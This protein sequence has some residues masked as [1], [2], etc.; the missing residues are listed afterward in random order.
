LK[1]P[2][3]KFSESEIN[4]LVYEHLG[5]T[6]P[7]RYGV[8]V[9]Y[10]WRNRVV[11]LLDAEEFIRV[12]TVRNLYKIT[13]EE[14]KK[15]GTKKVGIIGL[16]VG[17]SVA[18]AIATQRIAGEI[19]LADFDTLELSNMNRIRTSVLNLGLPK[20]EIVAR[21]IAELDPFLKV[22]C[23]YDGINE[24]NI[25][26]FFTKDG[27]IDVLIEECDSVE[28][29][30][31]SRQIAKKLRV[32]VVMDTSD[33]GMIDI[34]RFDLTPEYPLLH[35]LIDE[36][37]SYQYLKSLKGSK[38]K[39]PYILPFAGIDNISER[40]AASALEIESSITSWPQLGS[41]VQIG[42]GIAASYALNILLGK[43]VESGRHY[44]DIFDQTS[45]N[46]TSREKKIEPELKILNP[47]FNWEIVEK[48]EREVFEREIVIDIL[49]KAIESPSPGN[50]QKWKFVLREK[51]ICIFLDKEY[52][53]SVGDNLGYSSILGIGALIENISLLMIAYRLKPN[54]KVFEESNFPLICV[55]ALENWHEEL[56]S[57]DALIA[58]IPKRRT[59]RKTG[60]NRQLSTLEKTA[61]EDIL[62][63]NN[64]CLVKT[65]EEL[66][67]ITDI[68]NIIRSGD[69]IRLQ[70]EQAHHE[71]F[72]NELRWT[73]EE[74]LKWRTGIEVEHLLLAP[75][76]N[77]ALKIAKR[78]KPIQ[79]LKNLGLGKG[80]ERIS[81][82]AI[83]NSSAIVCIF[84]QSYNYND[85]VAAGRTIQRYWLKA[86]ELHIGIQPMTFVL[87]LFSLLE[88]DKNNF[89]NESE[90]GEL[91][92][93][94]AQ[95]DVLFTPVEKTVPVFLFRVHKVAFDPEKTLRVPVS[96]KILEV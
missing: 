62:K 95:F 10:P 29:K 91:K 23:Y 42:G 73:K 11:H 81:I 45:S 4:K 96:A 63:P 61:L 48:E 16:S 57:E 44:L 31:H 55:I 18:M 26:E 46:Y 92:E 8:W 56:L 24:D 89:L 37:L 49:N 25:H 69:R 14:Q 72:I 15:L 36:N 2:F 1:Y 20:V 67:L 83:E 43:K 6:E 76:D 77:A 59:N 80:F 70:N 66:G 88:S 21:E 7:E 84:V 71:F 40:M 13:P 75:A 65:I 50:N 35:G 9:F 17:H 32:P 34:E 27:N 86:T 79:F 85:L 47:N 51:S 52:N 30:I 90:L 78:Y 3:K 33:R 82:D 74:S 60:S 38:E 87:S 22:T 58:Q 5:P 39:L 94:K 28:I 41:E 93:M 54:I 68:G 19:R 12:R 53:A 64:Q